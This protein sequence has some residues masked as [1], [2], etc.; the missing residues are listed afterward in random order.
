MSYWHQVIRARQQ[1]TRRKGEVRHDHIWT[2]VRRALKHEGVRGL[3]SGFRF[4]LFRILPQ[5]AIIFILY[6][7]FSPKLERFFKE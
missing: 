7:R 2:V 1:D 4:D 5:N 6:E 3:Y